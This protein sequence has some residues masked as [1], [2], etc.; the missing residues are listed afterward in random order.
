M[1]S[2]LIARFLH[3]ARH[4]ASAMRI[5]LARATGTSIGPGCKLAAGCDVQLGPA[6]ERRGRVSLATGCNL[7]PG[8]LLH[9]YGGSIALDEGVFVGP[10]T[11]IYGHG[12]VK[13][14]AHSLIA[15]HCRIV[16]ANHA[17]P[18]R[19][20]FIR[21]IKDE[22]KPIL[23]G[24]DVWLGAGVTVLAGVTIGDGCIVGAGAVVSRDLPPNTIALGVPAKVVRERP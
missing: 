19:D 14:G 18:A 12:S 5:A 6:P 16:A 15:M 13:I 11:V 17:I 21:S 10:G 1:S 24:R 3:S 23:I 2:T 4:G 22:P 8:V 9:P 20:T 7:G